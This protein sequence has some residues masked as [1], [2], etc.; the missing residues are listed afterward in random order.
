MWRDPSSNW[1]NRVEERCEWATSKRPRNT[2][3]EMI[4]YSFHSQRIQ[5]CVSQKAYI[6]QYHW[7]NDC[8]NLQ[9]YSTLCTTYL[10]VVIIESVSYICRTCILPIKLFVIKNL[11]FWSLYV[12]LVVSCYQR[13]YLSFK[14]IAL[15]TCISQYSKNSHS[16]YS[17]TGTQ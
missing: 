16:S 4:Y 7:I 1:I 12:L 15:S 11:I 9:I 14:D 6:A 8:D 13:F 17:N 5:M 2:E 3:V 10:E